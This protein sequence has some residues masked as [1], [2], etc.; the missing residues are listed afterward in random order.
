MTTILFG[1][2]SS[3]DLPVITELLPSSASQVTPLSSL[4][5]SAN[6][7]LASKDE[8]KVCGHP[9]IFGFLLVFLWLH[10]KQSVIKFLPFSLVLVH[11][12][13]VWLSTMPFSSFCCCFRS[14]SIKCL[15]HLKAFAL[16]SAV[17]Y[18]CGT[19]WWWVLLLDLQVWWTDWFTYS[20]WSC[21]TY[22]PLLIYS[23]FPPWPS[24]DMLVDR[25]GNMLHPH[26]NQVYL[27][28][29]WAR[30]AQSV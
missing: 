9:L 11:L 6:T 28:M 19:M 22:C 13:V 8:K 21:S 27:A 29:V 16:C 12:L 3:C 4:S 23:P 26:Y 5:S 17:L 14:G 18:I 15:L 10:R 7:I 25:L 2:I 20:G 1:L 24:G 30:T